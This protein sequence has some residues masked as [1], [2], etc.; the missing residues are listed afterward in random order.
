M[1]G[2]GAHDKPPSLYFLAHSIITTDAL[3]LWTRAGSDEDKGTLEMG[4]GRDKDGRG[5]DGRGTR[6]QVR[7]TRTNAA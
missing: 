6:G 4:M 3:L 2:T 5:G 7:Q 1:R